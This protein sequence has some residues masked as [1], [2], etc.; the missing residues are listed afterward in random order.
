M[1]QSN[2]VDDTEIA[3]L[4]IEGKTDRAEGLRKLDKGYRMRICAC[5]RSHFPGM[6]SQDVTELYSDVMIQFMKTLEAYDASP[7]SSSFNPNEPL[8]EF[9]RRQGMLAT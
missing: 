5:L 2:D 7:D 8:L 6:R 9:L 3:L 4:L 1:K